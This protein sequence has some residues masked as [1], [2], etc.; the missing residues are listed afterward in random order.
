MN[1]V[2]CIKHKHMTLHNNSLKV[3]GIH[4]E[5]L[6]EQIIQDINKQKTKNETKKEKNIELP[7][8]IK[9]HYDNKPWIRIPYPIREIKLISYTEE[10]KM[11]AELKDKYLKLL[12]EKKLTSK[13]V[14]YNQ[15]NGK[16]EN[17]TIDIV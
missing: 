12:Y 10:K 14:E 2:E 17:I 1:L 13:V 5:E 3:I 16:I 8:E 9:K 7:S 15:L 4:N 6:T 11:N